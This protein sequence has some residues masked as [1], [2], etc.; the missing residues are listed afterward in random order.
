VDRIR[1]YVPLE[2]AA[3]LLEHTGHYH[4]ALEQYLLELDITVYRIHMQKRP[5][6]MLKSDKRDALGLA[7]TL[8]TQLA[9][10]AQVAEKTQ[11]VRPAA[12]PTKAAVQLKGLIQHRYELSHECTQRRNKLTSICDELFP[13]SRPSFAIPTFPQPWRSGRSFPHRMPLP[14]RVYLH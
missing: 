9:L 6:G 1:E 2:N 7:N 11:L 8:Y 14:Q 4:R 5:K 3:V 10:G 13:S 12:P